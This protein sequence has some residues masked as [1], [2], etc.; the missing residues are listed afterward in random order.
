[1]IEIAL[2][3][4]VGWIARSVYGRLTAQRRLRELLGKLAK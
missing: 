1:M 4:A 2:A 3:V